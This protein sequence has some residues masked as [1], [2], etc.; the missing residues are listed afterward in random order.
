MDEEWQDIPEFSISERDTNVLQLIGKEDLTGFTFEGL[1]KRLGVHPET[2]SRILYR[3]KDQG[4]VEKVVEGYRVTSKAKEYLRL[5]PLNTAEP[6]VHLLQTLPLPDVPVQEVVSNL[7][8]KWFRMLR[9][10][11]YSDNDE[12]ITLKWI[13][14]DG[15]IQVEV[16]F[17]E[18]ELNIEAKMLWEQDLN[19]AL[20]A[21]YQLIGY[22]SKL[23]SRLGRIS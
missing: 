17:S 13:T 10:L 11:G 19:I 22:I 2:L 8:G 20:R 6:R 3:L 1:K 5:E 12:G 7:R 16:N 14:E 21:S 4:V 9:W 23:Y 18:I 15:G